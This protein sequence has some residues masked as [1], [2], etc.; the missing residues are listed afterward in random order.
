MEEKE[1]D[2]FLKRLVEK[3]EQLEKQIDEIKKHQKL[4]QDAFYNLYEQ[5]RRRERKL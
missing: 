3:V 2:I 1:K 5:Q 4:L